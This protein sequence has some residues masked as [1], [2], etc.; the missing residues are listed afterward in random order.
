MN[1]IEA[2]CAT[3]SGQ[4]LQASVGI[5]DCLAA[6]EDDWKSF[7]HAAGVFNLGHDVRRRGV[8]IGCMWYGCG[9]TS[10]S[11]PSTMAVGVARSGRVTLYNGAVDIGQGAN[12]V[13]VQICADALG[14]PVAQLDVVMGD[15]DRTAD[16]GKSSA[17]RQ[18]FVSG[19]AAELAGLDLRAKILRL[20]NAAPEARI[21]VSA[22]FEIFGGLVADEIDLASQ[23]Q[24]HMDVSLGTRREDVLPSMWSW[25]V[26]DVP[27]ALP[28]K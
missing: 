12:T 21:E 4:V 11:N 7:Q 3:N 18:T 14:I 13:M 27:D 19:K 23:T 17:S 26:L 15:T 16:A 8:G 24:V 1:A 10:I 22:D 20:T 28:R 6:V 5:V 25:R 2:G 9:N